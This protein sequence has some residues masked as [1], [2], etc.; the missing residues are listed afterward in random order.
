VPIHDTARKE[1]GFAHLE[2]L[3][4]LLTPHL[5]DSVIYSPEVLTKTKETVSQSKI[6]D[7]KRRLT[8]VAY[9]QKA[10]GDLSNTCVVLIDDV[11]T[12]GATAHESI[13]ALTEA[14]A[15]EIIVFTIAH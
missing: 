7:R 15:K 4:S 12:T 3:C 9:T 13:R 5:P 8:N 1:K 10:Q 6:H 14:G 11:Y 2:T